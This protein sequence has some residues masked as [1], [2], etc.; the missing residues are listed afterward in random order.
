MIADPKY[1]PVGDAPFVVPRQYGMACCDCQLVHKI[2]FSSGHL[3]GEKFIED[4]A[5]VV[6]LRVERDQAET[7]RLRIKGKSA[8]I[9]AACESIDKHLQKFRG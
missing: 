5:A 7:I 3:V 1:P 8:G 9:L 2:E 4:P 6:R